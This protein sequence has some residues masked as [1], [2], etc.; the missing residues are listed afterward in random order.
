M[1]GR[2]IGIFKRILNPCLPL[3]LLLSNQNQLFTFLFVLHAFLRRVYTSCIRFLAF[4]LRRLYRNR[5]M[6]L[7]EQAAPSAPPDF[8]LVCAAVSGLAGW[9]YRLRFFSLTTI[10]LRWTFIL[11]GLPDDFFILKSYIMKRAKTLFTAF[12]AIVGI[13]GSIAASKEGSY[14]YTLTTG[15]EVYEY[16]ISYSSGNCYLS[17]SDNYCEITTIYFDGAKNPTSAE[18]ISSVYQGVGYGPT[19]SYAY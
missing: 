1:T 16:N 17:S 6:G 18:L 2:Y 3:S 5:S 9:G 19:E 15:G 8:L 10:F 4:Y 12:A 13:G 14:C 11:Q 7:F